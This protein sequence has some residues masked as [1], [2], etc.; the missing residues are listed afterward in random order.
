MTGD[1]RDLDE[2][3]ERYRAACPDVEPRA[4][5]MP[6]LWEK[7]EGR[8]GFWFA[9]QNLARAAMTAATALCLLFLFLNFIAAPENHLAP[10]YA[11]ALAADHT[12]E[13]TYYTEAIRSTP[14]NDPATVPLH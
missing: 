7:I 11:D 2:L 3:W 9:F 10:S 12:A 13:K 14:E 8:H 1:D 4:D 5:F 6:Q